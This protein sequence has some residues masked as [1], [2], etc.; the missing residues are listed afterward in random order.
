MGANVKFDWKQEQQI[1]RFFEQAHRAIVYPNNIDNSGVMALFRACRDYC[2]KVSGNY[3]YHVSQGKVTDEQRQQYK[4]ELL[5][6]L[7]ELSIRYYKRM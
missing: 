6:R 1:I 4:D 2:N 7:N 5:E 3:Y